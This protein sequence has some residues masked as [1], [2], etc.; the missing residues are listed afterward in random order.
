L[1]AKLFLHFRITVIIVAVFFTFCIEP[2]MPGEELTF[3]VI[4]V[5]QGLSQLGIMGKK[6]VLW[7]IGPAEGYAGFKRDYI[8][9]GEP[10]IERIIISHSDY[11]H[12]GGLTSIDSSI[13]WSGIISVNQYEDTAFLRKTCVNWKRLLSFEIVKKGD[14]IRTL[15]GANIHCLWP[16][17]DTTLLSQ[18]RNFNS[19]VFLVKY[20]ATSLFISSD[21]DSSAQKTITLDTFDL[22]A[23]IL[24]A[25]HHGS[26]NFSPFFIHNINPA[27]VII[28]CS[29]N[30]SYGHPSPGL[31]TF[32]I[33][34]RIDIK[35]TFSDGSITFSS[36]TF[37]WEEK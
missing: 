24:L 10:F 20:G 7:D 4:N 1:N 37:Y 9:L 13:N 3:T 22:K 18:Q 17:E 14:I 26:G 12:C 35:F 11:D 23:D 31:L 15:K 5:G 19:L 25:P 32:L 16:P 36:N 27:Q 33:S 8:R 6:A 29:E 30:N 28:S 34:E 21:I 2:V